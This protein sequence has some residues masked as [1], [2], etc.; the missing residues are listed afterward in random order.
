VLDQTSLKHDLLEGRLIN[1]VQEEKNQG[2]FMLDQTS[3]KHDLL[4]GEITS[5]Q[6]EKR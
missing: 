2:I 1:P 4:E 3:M 6:E 5:V